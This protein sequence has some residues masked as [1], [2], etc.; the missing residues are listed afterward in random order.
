METVMSHFWNM[1]IV[2]GDKKWVL[3]GKERG[4]EKLTKR[5]GA[6]IFKISH[7]LWTDLIF[8]KFLFYFALFVLYF[9]FLII[10]FISHTYVR[11]LLFN[12][13]EPL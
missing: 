11:I 2:A 13:R 4:L 10:N 9:I 6:Q 5:W 8:E 7:Y 1:Y 3:F 12:V